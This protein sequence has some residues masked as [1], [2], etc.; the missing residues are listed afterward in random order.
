MLLLIET[1]RLSALRAVLSHAATGALWS[2]AGKWVA[3]SMHVMSRANM[4]RRM[5]LARL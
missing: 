5:P 2:R 1:V 3:A 4:F